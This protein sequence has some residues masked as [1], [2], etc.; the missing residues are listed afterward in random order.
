MLT[1]GDEES[2][3]AD[4]TEGVRHALYLGK[5]EGRFTEDDIRLDDIRLNKLQYIVNEDRDLDLTFGWFKYGP[6]P[7]DVTTS[8]SDGL[9][10]L[11]KDDIAGIEESRLPSRELLSPEA[12][13]YYFLRELDD[14]FDRIVTA[15]DTK[16]YLVEF[17]EE[18]AP[19]DEYARE[20][21]DL[22]IMSA[23][24]QQTLDSIGD[25]REWHEDSMSYYYELDREFLQVSEELS[26]HESLKEVREAIE[27]YRRLLNSIIS[28]AD[29]KDEIT[30]RQQ[31]FI[32]NVIRK[33]YN[34]IWDYAAQ[35]ISLQ[36]MRGENVNVLRPSVE[37][38]AE[39]YR[40]G[41]WR[42]ELDTLAE[43]RSALA[44][45]SELDDVE[46]LEGN[47]QDEKQSLDRELVEQVSKMGGE[48]I[49]G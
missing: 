9:G 18:Y 8:G 34:T 3:L 37:A 38:N 15:K 1:P 13:A 28:E 35:E 32:R 24:L 25:G 2:L 16:V 19:E 29:T 4:I 22:Y 26:K 47:E 17:Y 42:T 39:R 20:F 48:V 21:V 41:A 27:E 14:E 23:R 44:L 11:S 43:R 40:Q 30:P 33:F 45:E 12:F 49:G 5:E 7:E 10:P 46:E 6:A 36:T 31:S